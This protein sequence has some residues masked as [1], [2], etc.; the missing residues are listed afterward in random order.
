MSAKFLDRVYTDEQ[1]G[2]SKY[3][4][5]VP[6]NYDAKIPLPVVL[7]LHGSGQVG[8][9]N[10]KQLEIGLG[11]AI[12]KSGMPFPF[13]GVFPQS[14]DGSWLATSA[15]GKR[16]LAILGAVEREFVTDTGRVYLTG[17]SMGGEGVWSLAAAQPKRFAAIVPVCGGGDPKH[18]EALKGVPCWAFHGDADE[19]VPVQATRDLVRA[20]TRAGGRAQYQEYRG[21]GHNCW[22]RVYA[23]AEMYRWLRVQTLK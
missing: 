2:E 4:I 13:I 18:A 16:A 21:V 17:V 9:D 15:D 10:K 20:I 6:D 14:R 8:T 19:V 12:R 23:Y 1:N 7:F 5:C 22:D 11:P 3:A